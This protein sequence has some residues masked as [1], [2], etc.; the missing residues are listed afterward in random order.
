M[1]S[2][3]LKISFLLLISTLLTS[4]LIALLTY[5]SVIKILENDAIN[6]LR[7]SVN[8]LALK[9]D[10]ENSVIET[11]VNNLEKIILTTFDLKQASENPKIYFNH[12]FESISPLI[13]II[14]ENS[15]SSVG[16]YFMA[17]TEK[18]HDVYQSW[19]L[20]DKDVFTPATEEE[21]LDMFY[22]DNPNLVWY[23]SPLTQ[24]KALWTDLYFDKVLKENCISFVQ[25]VIKDNQVIGVIGIDT[26]YNKR[27]EIIKS[28]KIYTS[29][30]AFLL[31]SKNEFIVKPNNNIFEKP[32]FILALTKAQKSNE[33][34]FTY[35]S[36]ILSFQKLKNS[37]ILIVAVPKNDIFSYIQP[38]Q[39]QLIGLSLVISIII[40]IIGYL[41]SRSITNNIIRLKQFAREITGGKRDQRIL[42]NSNDEM[43][44]LAITFNSMLD[45]IDKSKT[46]I[47]NYNSKLVDEVA[48]QT[49]SLESKVKELETINKLTINRELKMVELKKQIEALENIIKTK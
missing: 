24:K 14:S 36:H 27:T 31:D 6:N 35:L 25:P 19:Y 8:Q 3:K 23:Y 41:F 40:V 32:E 30:F 34:S 7:I 37:F 43:Q 42:L 49:N 29:G 46:E 33:S 13:K 26:S 2:L 20:L 44:D 48:K 15:N 47:E 38:L 21:S 22:P 28:E 45:E 17:N 39:F 4:L 18:Y 1:I 16:G 11:S 9:I 12:Y 10:R 5:L